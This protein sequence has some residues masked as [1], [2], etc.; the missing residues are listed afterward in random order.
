MTILNRWFE[1]VWNQGRVSAIDELSHPDIKARGLRDPD[2]NE[3]N[4]REAFKV[5]HKAFRGAISDMH[6]DVE[7]TVTEGD[8]TVALCHVTGRH[9]GEGLGKAP[10]GNT[11]DFT[12][13]TMA[14]IRDGKI[15]E[16]WNTFDFTTMF[17]QM[18]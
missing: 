17:Q 8:L 6:V 9:T 7:Q 15:A 10:K 5:F 14:R 3:V 1:E 11:I 2:G 12:G 16:A 18:E 13:M 4:G